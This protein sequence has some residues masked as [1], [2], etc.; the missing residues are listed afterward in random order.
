MFDLKSV[1]IS[2]AFNYGRA[3]VLWKG[4]LLKMFGIDGAMLEIM[5]EQPRRKRGYVAVWVAKTSKG[6]ITMRGKCMT[7]SGRKWW[8][9]YFKSKHDLWGST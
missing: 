6:D 3:R 4:G 9:I 1:S 2:G 5:S 7:C 8:P